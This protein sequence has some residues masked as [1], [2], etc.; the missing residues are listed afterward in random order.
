MNWSQVDTLPSASVAIIYACR[1]LG[2]I[3]GLASLLMLENHRANEAG[4]NP[5]W[6]VEILIIPSIGMVRMRY[7]RCRDARD[8]DP[9]ELRRKRGHV[10][11]ITSPSC[12]LL[13]APGGSRAS[14]I[15]GEFD[16]ESSLKLQG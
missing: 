1:L 16:L 9:W 11:T 5:T 15:G 2:A 10:L 14:F 8:H 6:R 7:E 13:C 4:K 12:H 3:S